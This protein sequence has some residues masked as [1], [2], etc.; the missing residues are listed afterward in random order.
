M[1]KAIDRTKMMERIARPKVVK[2]IL[3]CVTESLLIWIV[4]ALRTCEPVSAARWQEGS[5]LAGEAEADAATPSKHSAKE[6]LTWFLFGMGQRFWN[7]LRVA[8]W[9]Q[10]L[11]KQ[12][13]HNAKLP[14]E[15]ASRIRATGALTV[16][17]ARSIDC[18]RTVLISVD[19]SCCTLLAVEAA[20]AHASCNH[21]AGMFVKSFRQWHYLFIQA[22]AHHNLLLRTGHAMY[23]HFFGQNT[24]QIARNA[25][26]CTMRI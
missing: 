5:T 4:A 24:R 18:R 6:G 1:V 9:H 10:P 17:R 26:A 12:A 15:S 19:A 23:R 11:L 22:H 3:Y 8:H 7:G 14:Q 25:A 16:L 2:L 20:V 21:A 13:M